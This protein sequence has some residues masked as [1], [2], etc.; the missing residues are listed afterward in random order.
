MKATKTKKK[1][2]PKPR[3]LKV[4][5]TLDVDY[6][7]RDPELEAFDLAEDL[8][9]LIHSMISREGLCDILDTVV[10]THTVSAM[11]RFPP[12]KRKSCR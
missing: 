12:P 2:K 8:E 7:T 9:S 6:L 4:R 3:L 5:L 1:T 10:K 11:E